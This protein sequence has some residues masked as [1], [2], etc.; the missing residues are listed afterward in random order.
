MSA[1]KLNLA[2]LLLM[3]LT[4]SGTL[5]GEYALPGFWITVIIAGM[6]AFKGR[7][8]IDQFME[9]NQASPV[10]RRIVR[11]FGLLVPALMILT[12]LLGTELVEITQLPG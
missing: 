10:I 7:L 9:L 4:L 8:V 11:G 3:V 1:S 6:T 5:L 12:Y 2:W